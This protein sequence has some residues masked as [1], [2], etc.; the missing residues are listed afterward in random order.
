MSGL[1]W[2]SKEVPK[3]ITQPFGVNYYK[4]VPGKRELSVP[5]GA[6]GLKK[7]AQFTKNLQETYTV[8]GKT[9][10]ASEVAFFFDYGQGIRARPGDFENARFGDI[11]RKGEI[12]KLDGQIDGINVAAPGKALDMA[13]VDPSRPLL[14]DFRLILRKDLRSGKEK[15]QIK[16]ILNF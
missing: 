15:I 13:Y 5:G 14:I 10:S 7:M 6:S 8:G 16:M 2:G 1:S 3:D 12:N 11:R 4:S 9:I